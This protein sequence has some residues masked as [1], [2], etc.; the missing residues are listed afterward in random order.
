[1][2]VLYKVFLISRADYVYA[3]KYLAIAVYILSTFIRENSCTRLC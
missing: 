2:L 3:A 1:M